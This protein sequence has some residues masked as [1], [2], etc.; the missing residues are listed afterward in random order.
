L[1]LHHDEW[2]WSAAQYEFWAC[3]PGG[4]WSA[5]QAYSTTATCAWTPSLV[6]TWSLQVWAVNPG[7]NNSYDQYAG[8]TFVVSASSALT[9][10]SLQA[11]PSTAAAGTTVRLTAT[12]S[13]GTSPEYKFW[14]WS[15]AAG[16][17]AIRAYAT[18][19]TCAWTP[20]LAGPYY[21]Q[22]WAL[23]QGSPNAWDQ[24]AEI[25]FTATAPGSARN[26]LALGDSI[27][28]SLPDGGGTNTLS[29]RLDAPTAITLTAE[30]PAAGFEVWLTDEQGA[31]L[32][33]DAHADA[34]SSLRVTLP[35]GTYQI[36]VG[37]E[38]GAS[39]VDYRLTLASA[40][41]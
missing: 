26:T 1:T 40:R 10:V 4:A 2:R 15:A 36:G 27:T 30:G 38:T 12:P 18:T 23:N 37:S 35:A 32:G 3:P 39:P 34:K 25:S 19:P 31:E 9:G 14:A 16:W 11:S 28:G 13:G 20:S 41:G 17:T 6:G 7:S 33:H 22:V 8:M 21:L 29:L 5:I 24:Y